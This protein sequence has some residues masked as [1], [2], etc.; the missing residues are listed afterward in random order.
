[1]FWWKNSLLLLEQ[2]VFW[3]SELHLH[4]VLIRYANTVVQSLKSTWCETS[5]RIAKISKLN[6]KQTNFDKLSN[7][8]KQF[9]YSNVKK[10]YSNCWHPS[11]F[12]PKHFIVVSKYNTKTFLKT[13]KSDFSFSA[14]SNISFKC[15]CLIWNPFNNVTSASSAPMN[16]N[17][18]YNIRFP[19]GKITFN[20]FNVSGFACE[21]QKERKC[22]NR[23]C[24]L[25]HWFVCFFRLFLPFV[26][27]DN[28]ATIWSKSNF[29]HSQNICK[30]YPTTNFTIFD[31]LIQ[32]YKCCSNSRH[33]IL[34]WRV[35]KNFSNSETFEFYNKKI[36]L[37]FRKRRLEFGDQEKNFVWPAD[38][39]RGAAK[40]PFSMKNVSSHWLFK[41]EFCLEKLLMHTHNVLKNSLSHSCCNFGTLTSQQTQVSVQHTV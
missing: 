16:G 25:C 40:N 23:F 35:N 26:T 36:F 14:H 12:L 34:A 18:V 11:K 13:Y 31:Y 38:M 7:V 30:Q 22:T 10:V 24:D 4:C 9:Q 21:K 3:N 2:V 33:K 20:F 15:S 27:N 37:L 28:N 41:F 1:M 6:K 29:E 39:F 8:L 5:S 17:F 19:F 32:N